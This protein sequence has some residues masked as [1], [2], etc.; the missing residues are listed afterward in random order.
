MYVLKDAREGKFDSRA[1]C[2]YTIVGL[3][4]QNNVAEVGGAPHATKMVC[5]KKSSSISRL[6]GRPYSTRAM[7]Y[8]GFWLSLF[9][10]LS[11]H[12]YADRTRE[13]VNTFNSSTGSYYDYVAKMRR[14]RATWRT[15]IF[16]DVNKLHQALDT[17]ITIQEL[18]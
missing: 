9:L 4:P 12:Q 6:Q 2:P 13:R 3:T 8:F 18:N 11:A 14:A 5:K 17:P 7:K 10:L 1:H 15:L 16:L